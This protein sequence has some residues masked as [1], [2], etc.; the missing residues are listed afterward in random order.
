MIFTI[1][2]KQKQ[3]QNNTT[4]CSYNFCGTLEKRQYDCTVKQMHRISPTFAVKHFDLVKMH[5]EL[6]KVVSCALHKLSLKM[7]ISWL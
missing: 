5:V 3:E 2:Q 7:G 4:Q 6:S 1:Q